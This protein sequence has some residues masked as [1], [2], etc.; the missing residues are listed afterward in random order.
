[1]L[2]AL[3]ETR[4]QLETLR[5]Q[6]AS[7]NPEL[8]RQLA[9]YLQVLRDGLLAAVQQ[10]CF[11]VA[12]EV[13]PDRYLAMPQPARRRLHRRLDALVRRGA[14]LLTVEQLALLAAQLRRERIAEEQ[15]QRLLWQGG[16]QLEP[17][18]PAPPDDP[19]GSVR[20]ALEPPLSWARVD[21][22]LMPPARGGPRDTAAE[23]ST[24]PED[25]SE[26]WMGELQALVERVDPDD[27]D[28]HDSSAVPPPWDQG[29][30]PQD[31]GALLVWLDGF[32]LALE[33]RLRNLSHAINVELLRAELSRGLLPLGLLEAVQQGRIDLQPSHPNLI[34]LP[35]Q[36]TE[37]LAV[38][39]RCVDLEQEQPRLRTCRSRWRGSLLEVRKMAERGRLLQR[40]VQVLEAQ[41]LW[42]T[43]ITTHRP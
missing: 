43:D 16:E 15:M 41:Q 36:G 18:G 31:P 8:Y 11:H 9:L 14:S 20:L 30:L 37:A 5:Q 42:L 33:R 2:D 35:V 6:C 40:R 26:V 1:M 10:A 38:L 23:A 27:G 7:L 29:R 39:L 17:S 12:T 13:H 28:P 4:Q 24:A 25:G 22:S 3:G 32:E 21:S 34:R 19:P